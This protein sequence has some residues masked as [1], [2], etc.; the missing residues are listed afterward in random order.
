MPADAPNV[1]EGAAELS[2]F[3]RLRSNWDGLQETPSR[4]KRI[5]SCMEGTVIKHPK[6]VKNDIHKG[7]STSNLVFTQQKAKLC[8][9]GQI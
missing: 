1:H 2:L 6:N 3:L 7:C 8:P 4:T 5:L 9:N